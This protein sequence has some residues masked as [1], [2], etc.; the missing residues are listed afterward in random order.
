MPDD[1][2]ICVK[3]F[4]EMIK[5]KGIGLPNGIGAAH[6]VKCDIPE[7]QRGMDEQYD[8]AVDRV[9]DVKKN[10][11]ELL[12]RYATKYTD[13]RVQFSHAKFRYEIEIPEEHVKREKPPELELSS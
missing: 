9:E 2:D 6:V 4:Q 11:R 1:I 5:W 8:A 12:E 13:R 3:E 7:P 10:L